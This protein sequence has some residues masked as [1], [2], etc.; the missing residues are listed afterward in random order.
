MVVSNCKSW[1]YKPIDRN[2]IT[3]T[4]DHESFGPRKNSYGYNYVE[5]DGQFHLNKNKKVF[6]THSFSE[7]FGRAP[8]GVDSLR[9]LILIDVELRSGL[10]FAAADQPLTDTSPGTVASVS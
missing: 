6:Y 4:F 10:F 2:H 9:A 1:T 8:L 7:N 3:T 5:F